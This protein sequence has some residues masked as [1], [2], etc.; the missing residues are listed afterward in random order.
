[1]YPGLIN[2]PIAPR[3]TNSAFLC[4]IGLAPGLFGANRTGKIF[5]GDFSGNILNKALNV[6]RYTNNSINTYPH[7]TNA[8]KCLPPLNK[9]SSSEITNCNAYLKYE[10]NSLS[11]L[12]VIIAFGLVAHK[13]VLK[14][15]EKKMKKYNFSHGAIHKINNNLTLI[16][17]YHCSKINVNTKR[18]SMPMIIDILELARLYR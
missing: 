17:S 6:A 10:L 18:L 8:V 16:D 1:M 3:P 5:D 14:V 12:K 2:K 7:I 15:Y 4:I 11:N 13:A 9:P